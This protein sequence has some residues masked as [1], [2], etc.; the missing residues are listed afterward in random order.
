[1]VFP[2]KEGLLLKYKFSFVFNN[3]LAYPCVFSYISDG[4]YP[5]YFYGFSVDEIIKY[6]TKYSEYGYATKINI[7]SKVLRYIDDELNRDMS[8]YDVSKRIENYIESYLTVPNAGYNNEIPLE[9]ITSI[10]VD[11]LTES[12]TKGSLLDVDIEYKKEIQKV[13]TSI[14]VL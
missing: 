7:I 1:M 3:K 4:V 6:T 12:Y 9:K 8:R 5:L 13:S 2:F 10:V 11:S 14:L